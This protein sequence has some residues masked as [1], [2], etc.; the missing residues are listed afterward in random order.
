ML[1]HILYDAMARPTVFGASIGGRMR[2]VEASIVPKAEEPSR[3]EARIVC[4]VTVT[5]GPSRPV[6]CLSP[7][8][9]PPSASSP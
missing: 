5:E 9:P 1:E 4:E 2:I 7:P 6:T 8:T 3:T